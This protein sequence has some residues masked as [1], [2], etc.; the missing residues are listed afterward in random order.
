MM[1]MIMMS[2]TITMVI[3]I[4]KMMLIINTMGRWCPNYPNAFSFE[5]TY[6]LMHFRPSPTLK[7]PKTFE[8]SIKSGVF[9][10]CIVWKTSRFLCG[11][12]EVEA[13]ENVAEKSVSVFGR[14]RV[15]DRG[16]RIKRVSTHQ[17]GQ[18]KLNENLSMGENVLLLFGWY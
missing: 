2:M 8:N 10:R 13:F 17:C 18:V 14:F 16:K 11:Q 7:Y 1:T 9:W 12:V 15:D 5:N 3:V 6:F 4:I